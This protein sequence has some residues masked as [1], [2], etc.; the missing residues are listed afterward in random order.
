VV[1]STA[2]KDAFD[3]LSPEDMNFRGPAP[4]RMA[5]ENDRRKCGLLP[6][7]IPYLAGLLKNMTRE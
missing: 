5:R 6:A 7:V 4:G 1:E 2:L 3:E